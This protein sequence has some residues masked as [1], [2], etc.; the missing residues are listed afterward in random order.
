MSLFTDWLR[1]RCRSRFVCL[2]TALLCSIPCYAAAPAHLSVTE[3]LSLYDRGAYLEFFDV[4]NRDGAVDKNLFSA[5]ESDANRWVKAVTGD[6]QWRRTIVAASV[7]L[8]IAHL[9]RDQPADRAARYLA[10]ASLVMRKNPPAT[11]SVAERLW[12]LASVAGMEELDEPWA[13]TAGGPTGNSMLGPIARSIGAAGHLAI[14]MRRFPDEPRLRLALVEASEW[15]LSSNDAVP[16]FVN[17]ARAHAADRV[18]EE[19][20]PGE[21]D[22][23]LFMRNQ[24]RAILGVESRAPEVE[25]AYLELSTEPT[26]RPEIEL[27]VG[28]LE[29]VRTN[30]AKA[31]EH[32]SRVTTTTNEAYLRYLS[33]YLIG[34]TY[35]NTGDHTLAVTAFERAADIVP[36]ARSAATQLA[37]ELLG[38]DGARAVPA[39]PECIFRPSFRRPMGSVWSWRREAVARLYGPVEAGAQMK[40]ARPWVLGALLFGNVLLAAGQTPRSP[41]F[42]ATT[43]AVTLDVSVHRLNAPVSGLGAEDF[44]GTRQRRATTRGPRDRGYRSARC[45]IG[46]RPK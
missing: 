29:G 9:L 38:R 11:T 4:I 36:N 3:A 23:A 42:R 45:L 30:W 24:A 14:A 18:D 46:L 25:Q 7:A 10:W 20:Q 16:S 37:A 43:D 6:A 19:P 31:L 33:A 28:F 21:I 2:T 44:T 5:F 26:L 41:T 22:W 8:E 35:Q 17:L 27:H 32:L 15:P 34:R 40:K 12:Y 39:P 1:K 13:L